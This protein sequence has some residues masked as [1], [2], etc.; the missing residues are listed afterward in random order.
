MIGSL[1]RGMADRLL[2]PTDETFMK[3]RIF[4]L[5]F[6]MA[7]SPVLAGVLPAVASAY[8][9]IGQITED[10]AALRYAIPESDGIKIDFHCY[11]TS[12]AIVVHYE[13][14]PQAAKEGGK[15]DVRL[16]VRGRDPGLSV[17]I[18]ATGRRLELDDLFV[19]EG[20]TR[21]TPALRRLLAD[22][23][24]LLVQVDGRTE[25]IPLKGIAAAAKQ[26]FASCPS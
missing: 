8:R 16:S 3:R 11:R 14:A 15:F 6:S 25:E 21:M 26:L 24:S 9:W 7:L 1:D 19:L 4:L 23:G 2:F 12:R 22:G 10:G 17:T 18:A 20:E 13:H 5:A